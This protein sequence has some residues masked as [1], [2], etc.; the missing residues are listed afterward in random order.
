MTSSMH[1]FSWSERKKGAEKHATMFALV[2]VE[3]YAS[4]P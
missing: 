4:R 2:E 3:D 1:V